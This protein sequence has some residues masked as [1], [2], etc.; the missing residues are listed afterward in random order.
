AGLQRPRHAKRKP[1]GSRLH[2]PRYMTHVGVLALVVAMSGYATIDRNVL[3]SSHA[4]AVTAA[5]ADEGLR[6]GDGS[7]GRDSVIIK[8]LSIPTSALANHAPIDRKSVVEG[9][10]V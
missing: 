2:I 7:P 8:P 1:G 6:I 3:P 10:S 5:A 9:K 4:A